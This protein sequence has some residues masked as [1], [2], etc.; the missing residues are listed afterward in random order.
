MGQAGPA[1]APPRK[2]GSGRARQPAG[3]LAG[4]GRSAQRSG[5][6]AR[7]PAATA[8]SHRPQPLSPPRPRR[9]GAMAG[10]NCG[11]TIAL[12]GVLLLGAAHPGAGECRAAVA[13]GAGGGGGRRAGAG[14]SARGDAESGW[15]R[16]SR[17]A[18]T[19]RGPRNRPAPGRAASG[20]VAVPSWVPSDLALGAGRAHGSVPEPGA[21]RPGVMSPAPTAQEERSARPSRVPGTCGALGALPECFGGAGAGR[22]EGAFLSWPTPY[23]FTW[24]WKKRPENSGL[25]PVAR[26]ITLFLVRTPHSSSP[27]V[28]ER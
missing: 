14:R 8:P 18:P 5:C 11:A 20:E 21:G 24:G 3:E 27:E 15:G 7:A 25:A 23:L 17:D 12:L 2:A 1:P 26:G 10:Q 4:E 6:Q 16:R 13:S 19:A 9:P 28:R 22:G